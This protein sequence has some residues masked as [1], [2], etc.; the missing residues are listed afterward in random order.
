ME[1]D[2]SNSVETSY[3]ILSRGDS[4]YWTQNEK[5]IPAR[6]AEAAIRALGAP[7]T[8]VAIPTRSFKPVI[9]TAVQQTVLKLE[10]AK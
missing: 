2:T 4:D 7:G 1:T 8:Y 6:S 5:P 9:V 3:I 10:E